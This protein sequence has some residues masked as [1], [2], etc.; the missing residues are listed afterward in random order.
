[1]NWLLPPPTMTLRSMWHLALVLAIVG[2]G[3][4]FKHSNHDFYGGYYS[5]TNLIEACMTMESRSV[6]CRPFVT[7]PVLAIV[8]YLILFHDYCYIPDM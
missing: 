1:M 5:S 4:I 7:T 2:S 8:G 6:V 3:T